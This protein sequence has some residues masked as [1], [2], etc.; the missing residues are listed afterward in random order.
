[1]VRIADSPFRT[2]ARATWRR[3]DIR[4]ELGFVHPFTGIDHILVAA[5]L[6]GRA[7]W[8]VRSLSSR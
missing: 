6:G 5:Q 4:L 7:L 1:M 3:L 2:V 8:G